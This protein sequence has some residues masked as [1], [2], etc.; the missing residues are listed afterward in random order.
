MNPMKVLVRNHAGDCTTV[1]IIDSSDGAVTHC[2]NLEEDQEVV[3]AAM[4]ARSP[5]DIEVGEVEAIP[6]ETEPE[7][8]AKDEFEGKPVDVDSAGEQPGD[9]DAVEVDQNGDDVESP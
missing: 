1:E 2:L 9:V 8:E 5:A 4:T 7:E 3:V 6:S